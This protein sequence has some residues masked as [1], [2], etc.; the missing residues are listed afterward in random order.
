MDFAEAC[1]KMMEGEKVHLPYWN[2]KGLHLFMK[3][4]CIYSGHPSEEDVPFFSQQF[5]YTQTIRSKDWQIYKPLIS[6]VEMIQRNDGATYIC[7]IKDKIVT[8]YRVSDG[9]LEW[10]SEIDN[11]WEKSTG[12]S[13]SLDVNA[14]IWSKKT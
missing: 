1:N 11:M 7:N 13:Q 3:D 5:A 14:K 8:E 2:P 6:L 10:Y 12:I 9:A 4:G